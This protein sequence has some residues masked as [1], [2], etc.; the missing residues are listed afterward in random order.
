MEAA[1]RVVYN[2]HPVT[3]HL[4]IKFKSYLS[5]IPTKKRGKFETKFLAARFPVMALLQRGLLRIN[6]RAPRTNQVIALNQVIAP[7]PD[8]KNPLANHFRQKLWL[9]DWKNVFRIKLVNLFWRMVRGALSAEFAPAT[10]VRSLPPS[11][12]ARF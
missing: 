8:R 5:G 7:L 2:S 1:R 12:G 11:T 10:W 6:F 9:P 4:F 3:Q